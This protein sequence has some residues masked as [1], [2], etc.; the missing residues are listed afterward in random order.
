MVLMQTQRTVVEAVESASDEPLSF[1]EI[2]SILWQNKRILLLVTAFTVALS[3]AHL[4]T[5]QIWYRA[6]VLLKPV[7]SREGLSGQ[8]G[9]IGAL[10]TTLAGISLG[11]NTSAEPIAVLTS[12]EFTGS[13]IEQQNL[14]PILFNR[15]WDA[16][17]GRWKS[18]NIKD[19]PD[20]RD[21]IKYFSKS[22]RYVK[23]D[24]KTGLVTLA[25]EWTDARTAA[26]WAN[27]LVDRVND[28]MRE[29]AL[30]ESESHVTFL[31]QEL[32]IS[33][34]VVLQQ[35]I[36]HVLESELQKL[37][38]A[39][40]N[41]DFAFRIVDHAEVPK[42]R[43]KPQ[44]LLVLAAGVFGGIGISALFLIS[45]HAIRRNAARSSK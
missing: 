19:Q 7:E 26:T 35:S 38:L 43:D 37:M 42:W 36:S 14:L 12:R 17:L 39:K 1:F 32:T 6:E 25:I 44:P 13:F 23:E 29:R 18:A 20:I 45:R 16:A 3:L 27:L 4:F 30:Q 15:K 33:S 34:V 31:K 41:K 9:E 2:S 8:M 5:A 10:A 22:I 28:R 21:G 24:K 40:G 11:S